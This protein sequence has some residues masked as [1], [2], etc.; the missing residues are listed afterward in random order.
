MR[1]SGATT[2]DHV[3]LVETCDAFRQIDCAVFFV[4]LND[5]Q[6]Y[7]AGVLVDR[8]IAPHWRRSGIWNLI[9]QAYV[10]TKT[11]GAMLEDVDGK[12]YEIRRQRR[13]AAKIVDEL[14]DLTHAMKDYRSRIERIVAV[15][16]RYGV[17]PVFVTQPIAWDVRLSPEARDRLL[18]G[19]SNRPDGA[20]YSVA[21]L[22]EGEERYNALL[23]GT[24]RSLGVES[25]D[26]SSLNGDE[27]W[28]YDD[29]H[30]NE[31]GGRQLAD[32][33]ANHFIH[34]PIR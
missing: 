34:H 32:L 6:A 29:C 31:A 9:F 18:L 26:A 25:I 5:F 10:R 11:E 2:I 21:K 15:C 13:R 23:L 8:R 30:F 7:L 19:T 4:G 22:R 24:C 33:I 1:I 27:R 28:Y 20:Y 3:D 12:V 17:R 16:R 14:P